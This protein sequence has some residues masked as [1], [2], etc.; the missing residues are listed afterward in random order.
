M[1][2]NHVRVTDFGPLLL[3]YAMQE[4]R[5]D[6]PV[7][8]GIGYDRDGLLVVPRNH[9]NYDGATFRLKG[10]TITDPEIEHPLMGPRLTQKS[11]TLDDSI[12]EIDEFRF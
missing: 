4:I 1:H 7:F 12:I 9:S 5:C 2:R 8:T 6:I 3:D 11:K 10:D